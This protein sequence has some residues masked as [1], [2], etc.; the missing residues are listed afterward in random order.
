MA[1]ASQEEVRTSDIARKA[2]VLMAEH[3]I[4]PHP[5]RFAVYFE[6][7]LGVN[8][9]LVEAMQPWFG[10]DKRISPEV[11]DNLYRK[12]ICESA[13]NNIAR[14][15]AEEVRAIL[16]GI[17]D[18]LMEAAQSSVE[19]Q[20]ALGGYAN[21]LLV[22]T[23]LD[24]VRRVV[25]LVAQR[26]QRMMSSSQHLQRRLDEESARAAN[27]QTM[28][29]RALEEAHTDQLTQLYNR[30][31]FDQKLQEMLGALKTEDPGFSLLMLDVDH[32]KRFNDSHG[33]AVG[34]AVL[35]IVGKTIKQHT[36]GG[37]YAARYGGEEFAVLLPDTS[38]EDAVI[39]ANRIRTGLVANRFRVVHTNELLPSLTLS[40]G[41]ALARKEDTPS[42]LCD[43]AD[44]ALYLAKKSGRNTV[45]WISNAG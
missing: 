21:D 15:A 18:R 8:E 5:R 45:K 41:A 11:L 14:Q 38:L 31:A 3:G 19:D 30:K 28:L 12:Y 7:C 23:D 34:D 20:A 33:H 37:D 44:K 24:Q 13:Q 6:Y 25:E 2:F 16:K 4:A 42:T 36:K 9:Q 27:L 40:A 22:A 26:A 17:L 10:T 43:R 29:D 39:V 35:R 32:F 1:T